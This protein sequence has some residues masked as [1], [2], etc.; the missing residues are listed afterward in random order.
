MG[1]LA[2]F[3]ANKALDMAFGLAANTFPANLYIG[4]SSTQP[5]NTGGN[6]TEP[7][8]NNYSRVLS[9][10][11]ATNWPAASGRT[12]S[13]GTDIIFPAATGDWGAQTYFVIYDDPTAGNFV[14]YGDLTASTDI[15]VGAQAA[16]ITGTL[17]VNAPG[18]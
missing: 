14:A 10:N 9:I 3:Y 1:R 11:N 12:K 6:V 8:G 5:D 4:L 7:A 16:F 13:N 15:N 2:D 18:A 17:V